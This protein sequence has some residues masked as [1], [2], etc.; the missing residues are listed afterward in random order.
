MYVSKTF[1]FLKISR[2]K[3]VPQFI[4]ILNIHNRI[5]GYLTNNGTDDASETLNIPW[6]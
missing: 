5:S 6:H 3:Q 1:L 2:I 4:H